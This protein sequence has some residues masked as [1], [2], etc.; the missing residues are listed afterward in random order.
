MCSCSFRW[1]WPWC[2][3]KAN[4]QRCMLSAT[5]QAISIK[6]A[7]T[8]GHFY[9][10][11]TLLLQ[12]FVE[13]VL[14]V[15]RLGRVFYCCC[16]C[17]FLWLFRRIPVWTFLVNV[18]SHTWFVYIAL[19][20]VAVVVVIIVVGVG[21][22]G[23]NNNNVSSTLHICIYGTIKRVSSFSKEKNI[24]QICKEKKKADRQKSV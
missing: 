12:T 7:T 6:L 11:L 24:F 13:L 5:K 8:V 22:G 3:A 15:M 23:D 10:T 1:P 4:N 17:L 16:D 9:M 19:F 2:K 20:L 21:V 14:L 18:T